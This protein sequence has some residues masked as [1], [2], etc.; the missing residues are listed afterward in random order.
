MY[1]N[2]SEILCRCI[3]YDGDLIIY[4]Y[5]LY[6]EFIIF[7][8]TR[9]YWSDDDDDDDDYVWKLSP[10]GSCRVISTTVKTCYD[11]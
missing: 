3:R 8:R 10:R 1:E 7:I 4:G 6:D 9:K 2:L 11:L 5:K